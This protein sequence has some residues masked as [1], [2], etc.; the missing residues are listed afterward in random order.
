ML[1]SLHYLVLGTSL[2]S[3]PRQTH[4]GVFLC[5]GSWGEIW[6]SDIVKALFKLEFVADGEVHFMMFEEMCCLGHSLVNKQGHIRLMS[7]TL[8]LMLLTQLTILV[9]AISRFK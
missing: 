6:L 2:T 3:P 4:Q 8:L 1:T 7:Y 5:S 9:L